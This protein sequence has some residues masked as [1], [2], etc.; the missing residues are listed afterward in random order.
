MAESVATAV[1]VRAVGSAGSKASTVVVPSGQVVVGDRDVLAVDD[2]CAVDRGE[3]VGQGG[4]AHERAVAQPRPELAEGPVGGGEVEL[5]QAVL[6]HDAHHVAVQADRR[7]AAA[8]RGRVD[9]GWARW[10]RRGRPW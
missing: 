2:R 1:V 4:V 3:P 9:D 8:D 7:R 10:G 6:Q 5:G